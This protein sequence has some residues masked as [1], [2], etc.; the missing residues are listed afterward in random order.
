MV[1]KITNIGSCA[2]LILDKTIKEISKIEMGDMVE[3]KCSK[4]KIV[5]IKIEKQQ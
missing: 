1:K 3:I 2:G 4:N 5:I